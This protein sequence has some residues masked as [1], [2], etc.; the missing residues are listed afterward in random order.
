MITFTSTSTVENF[1][2]LG[3]PWPRGMQVASIGPITSQTARDR[4]LTIGVEA[5][6]HD[7]PDWWRRF[8]TSFSPMEP[9]HEPGER[10]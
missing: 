4:G 7:I 5:K 2:A 8:A 9:H 3:L 6:R 10:G 1:L